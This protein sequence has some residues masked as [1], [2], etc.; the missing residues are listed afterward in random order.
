M[1]VNPSALIPIGNSRTIGS[2]LVCVPQAGVGTAIFSSWRDTLASVASIWVARLPGR[3]SRIH[4][5]PLE[6]IEAMVD[7][8]EAPVR[9]LATKDVILFGHCSGA[10]VAYEL[11]HRLSVGPAPFRLRLAVSAQAA[12]SCGCTSPKLPQFE[13]SSPALVHY[14]RQMGGTPSE[15]LDTPELMELLAPAILADL[16]AVERYLNPTTR[17][18]LSIP[19]IAF[20]GKNDRVISIDDL[21]QWQAHTTGAFILQ[22]FEGDHFN[23]VKSTSAIPRYLR[24][25]LVAEVYQGRPCSSAS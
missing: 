13:S 9:G 4:E 8:L 20:G 18:S 14:L 11:A 2:V 15:V 17:P 23:L 7:I 12:P 6:T 1:T 19:I 5:R 22:L 21:R 16:S 24:D 25:M 3:E 10:L